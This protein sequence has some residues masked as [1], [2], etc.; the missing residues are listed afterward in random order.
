MLRRSFVRTEPLG[1]D[2]SQCRYW[3]LQG[4][5]HRLYVE[6]PSAAEKLKLKYDALDSGAGLGGG[7]TGSSGSPDQ[8]VWYC[9]SSE[10][11][12]VALIEA[13]DARIP[14]EAL[15]K[16]ALTEHFDLITAEMP[17]SKPGLLIS[18]L[19]NEDS[20]GGRK[21]LR[22]GSSAADAAHAATDF[23][24]WTN[25]RRTW[26][27]PLPPARVGID[28]V[29]DDL[30]ALEAWLATRLRDL[31]ADWLDRTPGGHAD[32][33]A[34][35][36]AA[37]AVADLV[38]PLLALEAEVTAFQLKAQGL[39]PSALDASK[40]GAGATA[41]RGGAR[42]SGDN[43][44]S[45]DEDDE[46]DDFDVLVDDGAA[47]WPTP[48]CRRRWIAEV[49]KVATIATL[50]AALA[51]L[52][53]RLEVFGLSESTGGEDHG[54]NT[55]RAK[56]EKEKRSRKERA[57]KK[58]QQQQQQQQIAEEGDGDG[59]GDG[60]VPTTRDS[61]D[62]WDEDCYICA[63]GGE[64]LCCDGCPRVFHYT[65]AGLRR[66]PR[67]KTFC[68]LCDPSVRPVFP[69]AKAT[70]D[71]T[72]TT[73][74]ATVTTTTATTTVTTTE[75]T[76]LAD[77]ADGTTVPANTVSNGSNGGADSSDDH[78]HTA[79]GGNL[80]TMT[81]SS[82]DQWD[83]DCSVCGL[84]GELLCCDGCPRA[85]HVACIGLEVRDASGAWGGDGRCLCVSLCV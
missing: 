55:R 39:A 40:A 72:A 15:L 32:W 1:R 53:Q 41:S 14:R 37:A 59:D 61:N 29:R 8:A 28:A 65:C 17:V 85:F 77:G 52:E 64:L 67:G 26:R 43:D 76:P 30:C 70:R 71:T 10:A 51:A 13:L 84:G 74:T 49:K 69:V 33:L 56:S 22:K 27:K 57:A 24:A 46:D 54:V 81:R 66:I 21:R 63:E 42:S 34:R 79:S 23:L 18:D 7:S 25:E 6:R 45:D 31:G 50:A 11:E 44:K 48:L 82:E 83:V 16:T 38:G 2:R 78:I 58:K 20:A 47:L 68:H 5:P 12:V 4:D 19:L 35:V 9:Y 60:P 36:R 3:L 75:P 73:T 62:E 80:Q